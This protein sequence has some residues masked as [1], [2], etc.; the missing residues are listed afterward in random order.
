MLQAFNTLDSLGPG[1]FVTAQSVA[2]SDGFSGNKTVSEIQ[3]PVLFDS[4]TTYSTLPTEIADS[5]GKF[6]DGKYSSDDQ[7][8]IA[9]CSKMNNTLLS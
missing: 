5:I 4:G 3:F 6:F 7:G 2:I 9:D 8:Y 1:M